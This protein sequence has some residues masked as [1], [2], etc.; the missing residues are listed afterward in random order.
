MLTDFLIT[1]L[2][3]F[4]SY[5]IWGSYGQEFGVLFFETQCILIS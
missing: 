5:N 1:L 4:I 3:H 2:I